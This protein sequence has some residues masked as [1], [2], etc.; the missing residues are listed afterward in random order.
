[1]RRNK[2]LAERVDAVLHRRLPRGG[3]PM[4]ESGQIRPIMAFS[5]PTFEQD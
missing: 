5:A 2:R 4:N 3:A 1:M